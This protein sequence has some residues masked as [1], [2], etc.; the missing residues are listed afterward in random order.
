[1]KRGLTMLSSDDSVTRPLNDPDGTM[2]PT[3]QRHTRQLPYVPVTTTQLPA[4]R[5]T[6]TTPLS[7]HGTVTITRLPT[8]IPA[9]Q[10]RARIPQATHAHHR[11]RPMVLVGV[12][13]CSLI[14]LVAVSLFVTPLDDN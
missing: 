8:V 1:M 6:I 13:L 14:I 2:A 12:M 5:V 4:Q 3:T 11:P 7:A 10:K 9:T